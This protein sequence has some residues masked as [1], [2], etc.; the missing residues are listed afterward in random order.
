MRI[1]GFLLTFGAL[2]TL[3]FMIL[4]AAALNVIKFI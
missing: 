3:T 2:G 4:V 1:L